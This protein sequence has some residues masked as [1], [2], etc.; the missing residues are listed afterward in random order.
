MLKRF[1][2][3]TLLLALALVVTG[4]DSSEDEA[5]G[6]VSGQITAADGVTPIPGVTVT[7]AGAERH[8]TQTLGRLAVDGPATV[9]DADG[10]FTL[11]D[12]PA[13]EQTLL[14]V[15]GAFQTTF[16][17]TV[18][19]G[20]TTT[21]EAP[22]ELVSSAQLAYVNGSYD[23]I[24]DV[25]TDL[26]N[27]ITQIDG[28]DLANPDVTGQYGV[29]FI[30][31]GT[32][33]TPTEGIVNNLRTFV[34][35]GGVLYVSDWASTFVEALYPDDIE[36]SRTGQAQ[37]VTGT[38]L[39]EDVRLFVDGRSEIEIAYDLGQW[40]RVTDLGPNATVLVEGV[41]NDEGNA[42]EPLAVLVERGE[43]RVVY[44]T[45]HNEAG[46]TEDQL[47]VLRYFIYLP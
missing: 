27:E 33:T 16:T 19:A 25:V 22:V 2:P 29:I 45:F 46:V 42:P 30:N 20:E 35:N 34:Q 41:V 37:E 32:N 28:S 31:C 44:T 36:T 5:T 11:N 18:E 14:A 4:C 15:R 39:E 38:I 9:T 1:H 47:A 8:R 40:A 43:G 24:E 6:S 13:G 17:V 7:L 12:V 3:L 23:S 10:N 26:G 21:V